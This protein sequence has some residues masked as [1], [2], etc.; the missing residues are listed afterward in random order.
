MMRRMADQVTG[1]PLAQVRLQ[2]TPTALSG[3]PGAFLLEVAGPDGSETIECGSII[4]ATGFE[5]FDPG[6][7]TQMYGYYEFDGRA[8]AAG[9]GDDAQTARGGAALHRRAA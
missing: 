9:P 3:E 6:R 2:T 5:H 4:V 7:E 8:D 1:H